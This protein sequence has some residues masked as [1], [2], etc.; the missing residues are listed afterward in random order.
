MEYTHQNNLVLVTKLGLFSSLK[1]NERVVLE[2]FARCP[3]WKSYSHQKNAGKDF[4]GSYIEEGDENRVMIKYGNKNDYELI[5]VK[6]L[7]KEFNQF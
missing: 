2:S 1:D 5:T 4:N 6:Q 3:I 7:Q